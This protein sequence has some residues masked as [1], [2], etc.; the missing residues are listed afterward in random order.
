MLL[1]ISPIFERS[2]SKDSRDKSPL[3]SVTSVEVRREGSGK[4]RASTQIS[5]HSFQVRRPVSLCDA[6]LFPSSP[7]VQLDIQTVSDPCGCETPT[8][9]GFDTC[10]KKKGRK[11]GAAHFKWLPI[12][13]HRFFIK[14]PFFPPASAPSFMSTQA[15]RELD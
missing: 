5:F 2:P 15:A 8:N 6:K 3:K 13:R 7:N 1:N 4:K 14:A 10:R 9:R 12:P 11:E